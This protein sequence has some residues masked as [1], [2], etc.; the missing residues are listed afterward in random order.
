VRHYTT[1]AIE[2]LDPQA[3]IVRADLAVPV[4]A[5]PRL[6]ESCAVAGARYGRRV[7][8]FGHAGIGILHVLIPARR[9]AEADW[10]AAEAAKD[11][12]ISAAIDLG[13][14]VSG[15]HGMGSGNRKYAARALGPALGLMK[16]VK[17]VFD[18]KGILNPGKIWE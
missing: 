16:A 11:Q 14:T 6:V 8:L 9:E 1:R 12:L 7:F 15:E 17:A 18:P 13:G 10:A 4:S 5:L 2:A 3:A